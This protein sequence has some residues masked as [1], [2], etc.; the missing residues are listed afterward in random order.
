MQ[1]CF[2][3]EQCRLA[4]EMNRLEFSIRSSAQL[5]FICQRG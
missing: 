3:R 5:T 4:Y 2:T 1:P